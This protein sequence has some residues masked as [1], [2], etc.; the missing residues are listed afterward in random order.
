MD[1]I[2]KEPIWE[3]YTENDKIKVLKWLDKEKS[4]CN[5]LLFLPSSHL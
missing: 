3:S 1:D 5:T 4:P 2:F